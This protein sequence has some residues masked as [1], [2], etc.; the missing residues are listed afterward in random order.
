MGETRSARIV[1]RDHAL[2][3][4]GTGAQGNHI[5]DPRRR[6]QTCAH[7]RAW[8][9]APDA[10]AAD[11]LSTAW[12]TMRRDEIAGALAALGPGHAAVLENPGGSLHLCDHTGA[13]TDLAAAARP[14]RA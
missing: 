3:A 14:P 5:I 6:S 9:L 2:G 12:M 10:A 11:A 7:I 1:L 4:S 8:A 13:W